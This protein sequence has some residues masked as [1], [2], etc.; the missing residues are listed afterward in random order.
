[1]HPAAAAAIP[2]MLKRVAFSQMQGW[3][4][5]EALVGITVSGASVAAA[6]AHLSVSE[7][8]IA[9]AASAKEVNAF[10]RVLCHVLHERAVVSKSPGQLS[11]LWP[12]D[13]HGLAHFKKAAAS[14]I[15]Y[16]C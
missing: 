10:E 7:A 5:L 3:H 14:F 8:L 1:M 6:A 12:P 11:P 13:C 4:R 2:C 16:V 15:D 9:L